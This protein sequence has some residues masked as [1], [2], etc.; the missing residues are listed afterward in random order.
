MLGSLCAHPSPGFP[1]FRLPD[2]LVCVC[3]SSLR[4]SQSVIQVAIHIVGPSLVSNSDLDSDLRLETSRGTQPSRRRANS[5]S[6]QRQFEWHVRWEGKGKGEREI[7]GRID[8]IWDGVSR[9]SSRCHSGRWLW[10]QCAKDAFKSDSGSDYEYDSLLLMLADADASS[11]RSLSLELTLLNGS[12]SRILSFCP[13][14]CSPLNVAAT[15]Q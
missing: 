10:L 13:S 5:V 9:S 7:Q 11:I 12:R 3:G 14:C 4:D 15:S 1:I 8:A 6:C 2:S